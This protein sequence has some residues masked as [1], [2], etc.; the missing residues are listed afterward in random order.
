MHLPILLTDMTI[1][2]EQLQELR[3]LVEDSV[4]YYCDQNMVSGE[5][6][7]TVLECLSTAKIAEMNGLLAP[8]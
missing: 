1:T 5:V 8:S 6:A 2:K 4:E 7:W 3:D